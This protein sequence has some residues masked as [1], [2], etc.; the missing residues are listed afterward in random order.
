MRWTQ[1]AFLTRTRA[2]RT[3]KSYGPDAPTLASSRRMM[4]R[5][6]RRQESP[7]SGES[8]KE[9]VKTIRAGNAGTFSA[10]LRRL[11]RVFFS[12]KL[13]VRLKRPA[14]PAPSDEEGRYF[15][16]SEAICFAG[17]NRRA[18][19]GSSFRGA[20]KRELW[21][22]I[23]YLRIH[24]SQYR[25]VAMDSGPAPFGASRNDGV[26]T[27]SSRA[28]GTRDNKAARAGRTTQGR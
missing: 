23:V 11:L 5:R 6:R 25:C 8:T 3:A 28:A 17:M 20:R 24:P 16:N 14:F 2:L 10:D 15:E 13:W 19:N 26:L 1:A 9:T 4:F 7:V 21:C 18:Q 27:R 22:A 12:R